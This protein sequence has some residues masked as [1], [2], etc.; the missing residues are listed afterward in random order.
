MAGEAERL[1]DGAGSLPE[2]LRLSEVTAS[3]SEPEG[4]AGPLPE[5]LADDEDKADNEDEEVPSIAA[6]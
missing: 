5:F 1:L 3:T 4:G 6:E 2:P